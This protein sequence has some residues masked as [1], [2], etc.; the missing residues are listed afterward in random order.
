[1]R[2]LTIA[3]SQIHLQTYNHNIALITNEI[4]STPDDYLVDKTLVIWHV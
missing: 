1:M 4:S 3:Y 2:K